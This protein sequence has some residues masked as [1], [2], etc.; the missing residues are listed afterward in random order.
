MVT[1]SRNASQ[2]KTAPGKGLGVLKGK[3]DKDSVYCG[4]FLKYHRQSELHSFAYLF[5]P[6]FGFSKSY[7]LFK[8]L[9]CP[10]SSLLYI[11]PNPPGHRNLSSHTLH[12]SCCLDRSFSISH[13]SSCTVPDSFVLT[14]LLSNLFEKPS[15]LRTMPYTDSP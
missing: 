13:I 12:N 11:L 10:N 9:L 2:G 1:Y 5:S 4:I 8:A 3:M 7:T 15:R 6:S 14:S